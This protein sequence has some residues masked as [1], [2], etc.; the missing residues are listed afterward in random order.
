MT[1]LDRGPAVPRE[2]AA[3]ALRTAR[4]VAQLLTRT[5]LH[6]V[7]LAGSTDPNAK[8]TLMLVDRFGPAFAV[9]IATT[10]EAGAAVLR[11][12]ARLAALHA[13]G[14]AGLVATV[15]RPVTLL[16]A[17][18]LPALVTTAVAGIP[19]AAHYHEWRHTGR[20]HPVR[21]D[22]LAAGAWLAA[23][24]R[25]TAAE[26]RP[27]TLL[28]AALDGIELRFGERPGLRWALRPVSAALARQR[29]P[30]TAVHG[31]YWF[32]NVLAAGGRVT[33]VVDWEASEPAG[34]PLADVARFAVS[35]CLY[36]DRHTRPGGRVAGHRGLRADCWG[37]GLRHAVLGDGWL[38]ATV[39]GFVRDALA[40]LDADPGL[41]RAVLLA[42]IAEVAAT[43]DHA[44]FAAEHL[45]LLERMLPEL[46]PAALAAGEQP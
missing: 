4:T 29:T 31:D 38:P 44:D 20:R 25:L 1:V 39:Q 17:D 2:A 11:E 35:Y 32:G 26:R 37:A 18:G 16:D 34:E 9:K 43:A 5:D 10:P 24:Q 46:R 23:L 45:G 42:G 30:R 33:G 22:L 41:A 40:R 13:R 12:A 36:L 6:P 19:M 14:L 21:A 8:L 27:V 15:P 7:L 3:P 28:E